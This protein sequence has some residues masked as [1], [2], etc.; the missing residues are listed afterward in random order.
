LPHVGPP[1][2]A[3]RDSHDRSPG[4]ASCS[5][6]N[7]PYSRATHW[8]P[9]DGRTRGCWPNVCTTSAPAA[10]LVSCG[11]DPIV[12]GSG[13]ASAHRSTLRRGE[14]FGVAAG[15][16]AI[17]SISAADGKIGVPAARI[18]PPEAHPA[19]T[20]ARER[21]DSQRVGRCISPGE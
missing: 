16:A 12:V 6:Q 1:R 21:V 7:R 14:N 13:S 3:L 8:I 5:S 11:A 4:I 10:E 19:S 20:P 15:F 17:C 9:A 18:L 2:H